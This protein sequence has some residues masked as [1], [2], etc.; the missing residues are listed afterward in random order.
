M[1]KILFPLLLMAAIA[2]HAQTVNITLSKEFT[3]KDAG[4]K[5]AGHPVKMGGFF[6][7]L[8]IKYKGAQ[9][10]YTAKL[11]KIKYSV[12]IHKLDVDMKELAHYTIGNGKE[13]GPFPAR[14]VMYNN[15]LLVFY[16]Q[17]QD[18]HVIKLL[19]TVVDPD[20]MQEK[21]ASEVCSL[22]EKNTG[23]FKMLNSLENNFLQIKH[24]SDHNKLLLCQAGNTQQIFT[25]LI[26][27][28]YQIVQPRTSTIN[29][30]L[31]NF[32]LNT[33]FLDDNDNRYISYT[34]KAGKINKRGVLMQ[35]SGGKE[36]YVDFKTGNALW[37]ANTLSFH[38]GPDHLTVY[39]YANFYGDYFDE[40][41]MLSTANI[42][43]FSFGQTRFFPYPQH[44]R[45]RLGTMGFGE[46]VKDSYT[47][48][49]IGYECYD[50][51]D[52]SLAFSG[53][54]IFYTSDMTSH[55]TIVTTFGGPIINIFIMGNE[56]KW[57]VIYRSIREEPASYFT[58]MP[59]H[60]KL[61]LL[62]NDGPKNINI[63]DTSD[64]KDIKKASDL[65]LAKAVVSNNGDI[66][67][68][69]Q[70]SSNHA[71]SNYYFTIFE[72]QVTQNEYIIP[73]G[74][75]RFNLARYYT[76]LVQY[77]TIDIKQ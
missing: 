7:Q 4:N 63:R 76:E 43:D 51:E 8:E 53:T 13:F 34:Y 70:I 49:P 41:L 47:I 57:G 21:S 6:Y 22:T 55:G 72:Q 14:M 62:Y 26:N 67:S 65:V 17:V 24:S 35:A 74:R 28:Q 16:Y 11:E 56:C 61:L 19:M 52:G 50:M 42:S 39:I 45:Q 69:E 23:F 18:E 38:M 5:L 29:N 3:L 12:I 40:G 73:I 9:L 77:A 33:S 54:P 60:N 1:K 66:L 75:V 48:R 27:Q 15:T 25:C 64:Y 59:Y 10:A 31:T 20:A 71:G 36:E 44:I 32:A 46:K 2:I 37:D 68:K 30:R 58:A